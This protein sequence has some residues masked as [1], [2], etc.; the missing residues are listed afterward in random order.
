MADD[1]ELGEITFTGDPP[2]EKEVDP[3]PK[4]PRNSRSV[5]RPSNETKL[6]DVKKELAQILQFAVLPLK[7]RD[8]HEDG[9]SCA[10]VFID[11]NEETRRTTLTAAADQW[12]DAAAPIVF[13]S[14]FLMKVIT[15]GEAFGKWG[16]FAYATY[17]LG[18]PIYQAHGGRRGHE[19][20]DPNEFSP[21]S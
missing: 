14:P 11:Y 7:F 19:V 5:G 16:K 18:M 12:V 20:I 15:G 4:P 6:T 9:T 2:K 13:D 21:E 10:D 17:M 3:A 8:I 1:L